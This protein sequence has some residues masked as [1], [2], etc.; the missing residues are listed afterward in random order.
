[1]FKNSVTVLIQHRDELLILLCFVFEKSQVQFL[2]GKPAVV[3]QVV[4][5][6]FTFLQTNA[7]PV[8]ATIN[9]IVSEINMFLRTLLSPEMLVWK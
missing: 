9:I 3:T 5:S 6:S 7:C 4:H 8:T 2:A 1:M